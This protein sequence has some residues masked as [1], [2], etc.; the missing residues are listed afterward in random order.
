MS[1]LTIEPQPIPLRE[2][3]S[4]TI[5]IGESRV[6]LETVICAFD[7]GASPEAIVEGYDTLTLSDV[8][9]VLAYYLRNPDQVKDYLR[10]RE[11]ECEDLRRQ[12]EA[13]QPPR[14]GMRATLLARRAQRENDRVAPPH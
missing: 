7:D 13:A 3:E 6:L 11:A 9:A 14:P 5:R 12:I 4:G 8:Y 2:D 1:T 10:K